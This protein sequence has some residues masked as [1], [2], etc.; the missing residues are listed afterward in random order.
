MNMDAAFKTLMER[1]A[2]KTLL[3]VVLL[4]LTSMRSFSWYMT[5]LPRQ[6]SKIAFYQGVFC[7]YSKRFQK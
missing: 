3:L 1:K 2:K 6:E 7:Q 5:P 4:S